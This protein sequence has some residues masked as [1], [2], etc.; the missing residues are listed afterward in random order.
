MIRVRPIPETVTVHVPFRLVKRGGRK[1]MVL[2]DCSPVQR[3]RVDNTMIK[4]LA[5]A[6]RWKRM[7]ESGEFATTAELAEREGIA[8]TYMT[9]VLRLTLL[10]P[11]I[12]DAIVDGRQGLAVTLAQLLEPLPLEWH[13]QQTR[14][15]SISA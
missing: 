1:K 2:P 13:L 11:D 6:F 9:R 7:M 14:F 10:A 3:V 12:I 5:R 8:A 15:A 4:A